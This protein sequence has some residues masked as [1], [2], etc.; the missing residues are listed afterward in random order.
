MVSINFIKSHFALSPQFYILSLAIILHLASMSLSIDPISS[1]AIQFNNEA[2]NIIHGN[3]WINTEGSGVATTTYPAFVAFLVV[4]K[5]FF[6]AHNYYIP[7]LLQHLFVV[8]SAYILY[9]ICQLMQL[10]RG[11]SL[12]AELLFILFH[13]LYK[14]CNVLN[15]QTL[16]VFLPVL[17]FFIC[18]K[19]RSTFF[20]LLAGL[21]LGLSVLTRFTYQYVP[22][23]LTVPAIVF[24]NNKHYPALLTG[25]RYIFVVIGCLITVS[26]WF[27]WVNTNQAGGAGYSDAWNMV[28]KFNA[29]PDRNFNAVDSIRA[30]IRNGDLTK[31][32]QEAYYRQMSIKL[33]ITH[34]QN[35]IKNIMT[36]TT[37]M[38]VNLTWEESS[39]TNPY[40]SIYLSILLGYGLLGIFVIRRKNH[41]TLL[42][43]YAFSLVTYLVHAIA[44]GLIAHFYIFWFAF[45]PS[46]SAGIYASVKSRKLLSR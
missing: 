41:I 42:P 10:P 13:N 7:V 34:P 29:A 39:Y 19:H 37:R 5:T 8:F 38:L 31:S 35:Y 15:T 11:I 4:C 25:K 44:Y 9:R 3:G 17:F 40:T 36:N 23:L 18:I 24:R 45:I 6:G 26:P 14:S 1:D 21:I 2:L 20:A 46:I 28:Y 32:E 12:L 27:Y 22:I 30:E 43:L 33:L 16:G